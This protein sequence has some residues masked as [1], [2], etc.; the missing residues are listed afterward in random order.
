MSPRKRKC[1]TGVARDNRAEGAPRREEAWR[2]LRIGDGA[3]VD[4]KLV[5]IR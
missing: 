2:R 3:G 1:A 4:S 5:E